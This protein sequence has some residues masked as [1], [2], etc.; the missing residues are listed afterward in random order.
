MLGAVTNEQFCG[1]PVEQRREMQEL[2]TRSHGSGA[3][4][5][6]NSCDKVS[7]CVAAH[8]TKARMR[9]Q[10]AAERRGA[11]TGRTAFCLRVRERGV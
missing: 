8:W 10:N 5:R 6:Q 1:Y 11:P 3:P 9:C 7:F 4:L 2:P